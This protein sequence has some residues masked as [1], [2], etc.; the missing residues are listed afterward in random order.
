MGVVIFPFNEAKAA[1]CAAGLLK[2]C[3]SGRMSYVKLV[4]L[5]YLVDREAFLDWGHPVTTD[6]YVITSSGP[7][8]S[9]VNALITEG[10]VAPSDW[11]EYISPLR[12][13]PGNLEV[14]LR[15][16]DAP[17]SELSMAEEGL[18]A[19]V[20]SRH[21]SKTRWELV[22][23]TKTLPEWTDPQGSAIPLTYPDLLKADGKTKAEI[24]AI[25][26]DL[27]SHAFA[28]SFFEPL[29]LGAIR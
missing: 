10:S 9:R 23:F 15:L 4:R 19:E 8:L 7:I 28:V 20:F 13:D 14:E 1:Q 11:S 27:E 16:Q 2:L 18:M 24:A 21:S 22:E 3:Q 25:M 5:M 6:Q 12:G 29:H 26:E 17:A